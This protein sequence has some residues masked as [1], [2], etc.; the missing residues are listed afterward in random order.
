MI[1]ISVM[2]QPL[3][4]S[5][6]ATHSNSQ[7]PSIVLGLFM[8]SA[9]EANIALYALKQ[10]DFRHAVGYGTASMLSLTLASITFI[11]LMTRKT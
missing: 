11:D 8:L 7:Q 3:V 4:N 10:R 2:T 1:N 6:V 9:I 5:T